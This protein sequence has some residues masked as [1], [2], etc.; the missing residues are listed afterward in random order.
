MKVPGEHSIFGE[1]RRP[2][3][4]PTSVVLLALV[5]V[6]AIFASNTWVFGGELEP[7]FLA[8][9][10]ST[11]SAFSYLEEGQAY[12]LAGD[13][14][15]S[16]AAYED[17]LAVDPENVAVLTELARIQAYSSAL[18][19]PE[20]TRARLSEARENIEKAVLLDDFSSDAHAVRTL[21][22]DWSASVALT[23]EER[24]AFLA[25]AAQSAVRA[26]R[27]R[28]GSI[29]ITSV[30]SRCACLRCGIK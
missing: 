20:E 27:V 30:P 13:L 10:T 16:I 11:R 14:N 1:K 8:T 5:I 12:F 24:E 26:V 22:L 17:A 25:E 9:P 7:M 18:L 6:A 15:A 2:L 28:R 3:M 4:S 29:T 21:V 23:L 19:T